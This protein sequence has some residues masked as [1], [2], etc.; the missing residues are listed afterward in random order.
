MRGTWDKG[1][2]EQLETKFKWSSSVKNKINEEEYDA[3][4]VHNSQSDLIGL[5]EVR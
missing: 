2:W 3:K 1:R 4:G 5:V